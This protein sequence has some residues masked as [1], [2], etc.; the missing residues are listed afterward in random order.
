MSAI[1]N[2]LMS[3]Y[4][5]KPVTF[6]SGSGVWLV[7]DQ[8]DKYLDALAGIAV[9]GLGHAHPDVC[10]AI[11]D[12][13]ATLVHTSNIYRIE[14][15]EELAKKLCHLSSMDATFFGN[16]GAEGVEGAMKFCRASSGREKIVY[17]KGG[18]HGLTLGSLSINGD[19]HFRERLS[20]PHLRTPHCPPNG[21]SG[22][23]C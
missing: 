8:Q 1:E 10:K 18:F 23:G 4:A 22:D 2:N 13:A 16:S 14:L 12:Q 9:C 20:W 21:R 19:E 17:A 15:Q 6:V 11:A 3:T 5:R 7:S